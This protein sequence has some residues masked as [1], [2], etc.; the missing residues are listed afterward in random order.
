MKEFQLNTY[1]EAI[2]YSPDVM[3]QTMNSWEKLL[4]ADAMYRRS[5]EVMKTRFLTDE[6]IVGK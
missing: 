1:P 2:L 3:I 6:D 4:F 5:T